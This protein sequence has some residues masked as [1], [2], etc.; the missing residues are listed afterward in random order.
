MIPIRYQLIFKKLLGLCCNV[1]LQV[2]ADMCNN[3]PTVRVSTSISATTAVETAIVLHA[4]V[5][6]KNN[7]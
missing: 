1:E 6:K 4:K 3:V 5:L 2:W 7:G